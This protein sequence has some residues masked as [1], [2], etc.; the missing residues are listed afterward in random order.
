MLLFAALA[1]YV[2]I[3]SDAFAAG[4]ATGHISMPPAIADRSCSLIYW[5]WLD[6]TIHASSRYYLRTAVVIVTPVFGA[7]AALSA[8]SADGTPRFSAARP[9]YG[10]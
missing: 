5:L 10:R 6:H 2:V 8:M 3:F 4:P 9:G 7:L 1:G